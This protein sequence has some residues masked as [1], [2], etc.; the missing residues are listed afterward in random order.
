M[1]APVY[2]F[3]SHLKEIEDFLYHAENFHHP[4]VRY[5]NFTSD[6]GI[7]E[8]QATGSDIYLELNTRTGAAEKILFRLTGEGGIIH[9]WVDKFRREFGATIEA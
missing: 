9:E 3:T 2:E 1:D 5:M 8:D 7:F 4:D 6:T